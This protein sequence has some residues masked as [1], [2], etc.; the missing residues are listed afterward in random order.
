M[1]K[2]HSML[3]MIL[4]DYRCALRSVAQCPL[5]RRPSSDHDTT[6]AGPR[7]RTYES[8]LDTQACDGDISK[9]EIQASAHTDVI[10][11]LGRPR[12]GWCLDPGR[13]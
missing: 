13:K 3:T 8:S 4:A 6:W 9:E 11:C 7:Q 2:H 12:P 1:K 10:N 5:R